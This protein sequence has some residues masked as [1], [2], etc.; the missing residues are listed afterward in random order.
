MYDLIAAVEM[1]ELFPGTND[2]TWAQL[3]HRGTG[4][5]YIK[6]ARKVYYRRAD[7]QAWID[8]NVYTRTDCPVVSTPRRT[9]ELS[10]QI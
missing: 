4:P 5:I 8:S 3:R 2:Q 6:V 9:E 10:G 7:V 1:K